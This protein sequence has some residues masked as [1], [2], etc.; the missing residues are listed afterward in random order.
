MQKM[1]GIQASPKVFSAQPIYSI[2]NLPWTSLPLRS[3]RLASPPNSCS[4]GWNCHIPS[5]PSK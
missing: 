5:H 3:E 1:A 4:S 2:P